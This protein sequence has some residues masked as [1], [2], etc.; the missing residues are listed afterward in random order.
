MN[1]SAGRTELQGSVG[2][3]AQQPVSVCSHLRCCV[4]SGVAFELGTPRWFVHCHEHVTVDLQWLVSGTLRENVLYGQ[5][6]D[7]SRWEQTLA[8]CGLLPDLEQLPAGAQT[9]IGERG[10]NISGEEPLRS[11]LSACACVSFKSDS[12]T[13]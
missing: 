7:K 3:C 9:V 2:Y 12:Q 1:Q 4:P 5:P 6:F 10:I 8:V 11:P 13:A